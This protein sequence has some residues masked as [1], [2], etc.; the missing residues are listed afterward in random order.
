MLLDQRPT[1]SK[2]TKS[3]MKNQHTNVCY[4]NPSSEHN[5]KT[6]KNH[7]VSFVCFEIS[8]HKKLQ[9]SNHT[10]R[11]NP[12]NMKLFHIESSFNKKAPNYKKLMFEGNTYHSSNEKLME[13]H[14]NSTPKNENL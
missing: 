14:F 6:Q 11:I 3:H 1:L 10:K 4:G 2:L 12:P 7:D 9:V 13:V 5:F 8:K